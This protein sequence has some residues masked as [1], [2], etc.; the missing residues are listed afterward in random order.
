MVGFRAGPRAAP[1]RTRPW[2]VFLYAG[3]AIL[4]FS[5]FTD[6]HGYDDACLARGFD[7]GSWFLG[8]LVLV[9]A[10]IAY[11]YVWSPER[12]G[13]WTSLLLVGWA[14]IGG[15][16]TRV[17]WAPRTV[18]PWMAALGWVAILACAVWGLF[19]PREEEIVIARQPGGG[20]EGGGG[21]G[22]EV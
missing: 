9:V 14:V 21:V 7:P 16:I 4:F 18:G 22:G 6:W 13:R 8:H 12:S 19:I 17:Y 15:F 5:H 2:E 10:L 11:A 20:N 1:L 3:V